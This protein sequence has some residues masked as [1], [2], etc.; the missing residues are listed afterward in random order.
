MSDEMIFFWRGEKQ[1][2]S[3]GEDLESRVG[4]GSKV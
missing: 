2:G 4:S 3:R 1:G